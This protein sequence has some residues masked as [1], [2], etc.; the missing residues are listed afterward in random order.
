LP[1]PKDPRAQRFAALADQPLSLPELL[2]QC[3]ASRRTL[4]RIFHDE[5]AM[6][7]GQWLRRQKL[8]RALRLLAGGHSV[9]ET[10]AELSYANP[11]AFIAMFRR[12][13][14]ETPAR[15]FT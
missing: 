3:G 9:K 13:L 1:A 15:Y 4:E 10:A 2:R 5:T 11:G 8:L 6:S 12:E 14:G 7:L